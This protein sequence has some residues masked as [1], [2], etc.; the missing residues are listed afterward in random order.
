MTKTYL[1]IYNKEYNNDLDF[2]N[3]T[4]F[5]ETLSSLCQVHLFIVQS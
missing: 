3:F 4:P 1:F 2:K 5:E